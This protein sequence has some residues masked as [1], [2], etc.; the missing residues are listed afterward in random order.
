VHA[1]RPQLS[2]Q[3]HGH[4][5]APWVLH[6]PADSNRALLNM[7]HVKSAGGVAV[8]NTSPNS[9]GS[10]C[11]LKSTTTHKQNTYLP[12]TNCSIPC[13]NLSPIYSQMCNL[14]TH[15]RPVWWFLMSPT[16]LVPDRR[17]Y[18]LGSS[19]EVVQKLQRIAPILDRCL[20]RPFAD[21]SIPWVGGLRHPTG[22]QP[23]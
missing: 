17:L 12:L 15:P 22:P 23:R 11:L 8:R 5:E 16:H 9:M 1:E 21:A 7:R 4:G 2:I 20:P 10:L 6:P 14:E 18:T 13:T 19:H 3:T